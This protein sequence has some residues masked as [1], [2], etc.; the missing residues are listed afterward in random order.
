MKP[1]S[2]QRVPPAELEREQ[3]SFLEEIRRRAP[4]VLEALRDEALPHMMTGQIVTHLKHIAR[5]FHLWSEESNPAGL[6]LFAACWGTLVDWREHPERADSLQWAEPTEEAGRGCSDYFVAARYQALTGVTVPAPSPYG[7]TFEYQTQM[8]DE[9]RET[10][11]EFVTRA[12][13]GLEQK[14]LD[15]RSLVDQTE[16]DFGF[17]KIPPKR[18]EHHYLWLVRYQIK[19]WSKK[20]LAKESGKSWSTVYGAIKSTSRYLIGEYWDKW[21]R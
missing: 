6:W 13:A 20:R 2:T 3:R 1:F 4:E 15:L 14:L 11:S 18:E 21:L 17:E 5:R 9:H 8:W 7:R 10:W 19:G 12:R 16:K